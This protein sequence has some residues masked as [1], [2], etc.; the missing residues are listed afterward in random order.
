MTE[1][2]FGTDECKTTT[3]YETFARGLGRSRGKNCLGHRP[4]DPTT[5]T[6][7]PYSWQ[8][9]EEVARRRDAL[10]AG[11]VKLHD[12]NRTQY[13]VG[14]FSKNRPEWAITD[15]ACASQSLVSVALYDTLGAD[16]TEYIVNHCEM[17]MVVCSL[18]HVARLLNTKHNM[19][20]LRFIVS[21][22]ELDSG[23]LEGQS[24]S[25]MLKLWASEKNVQVFSFK[26]V[27]AL[28]T[29]F[30]RAHCIP[31]A[32]DI[33]T[34]NYTSGTTGNPKGAVLQHRCVPAA[35]LGSGAASGARPNDVTFSSLP[36]A[37]CYQRAIDNAAFY[38]GASI[39]YFHGD[40]LAL[41]EDM[42][43]LQPTIFPSV[44][45]ILSRFAAAIRLASINAPGLAG[46]I[47]RT[48]YA[49]KK[50]KIEAGGDNTHVLWDRI[51]C[52][53]IRA[54]FGGRLRL[55]SSGSAPISKDDYLFL[56]AALA[57]PVLNG[58][59]LTETNATACVAIPGDC[60]VG[61]CGPP[62]PLQEFK[63]R[64][65][66]SMNYSA[67]DPVPKGE[68]MVRGPHI[69]KEYL[70]EPTKT[71]EA[72]TSDGWFMT[73][74]IFQIDERGRFGMIDRVKNFFKLAQGEYVAP[75]KVEN[76]LLASGICAQ[77]FVHGNSEES[78]LVA[79]GGVNPDEFCPWASKI[80][81]RVVARDAASIQAACDEKSVKEAYLQVCE[82]NSAKS[83]LAGFEK[84]KRI[85]LTMD[86]FTAENDLLTPTMKVKRSQAAKFYKAQIDTMYS[87]KMP[88]R[89][90]KI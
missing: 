63:L 75:E 61:H 15:L 20:K 84:V 6:Y 10:G 52:K 71:A 43:L 31:S 49:A 35:A 33:W 44:P 38:S 32:E 34:I 69:F 7:G 30:P 60:S 88:D 76:V 18:D 21:M 13:C 56:N 1:V 48:A 50:A 4:Y 67:E 70:K 40:M 54:I 74:D 28:G 26:E 8:T 5:K 73:G 68:L 45:R 41:V 66:P 58:Y 11:I 29:A 24:T 27:E 82:A 64:S 12:N 57:C 47:S 51:W 42:Q 79:I 39:G 78:Y 81:G 85:Y 36:L 46:A 9:Y 2:K 72:L 83:R 25:A 17:E 16:S 22:D 87:E 23:E 80:L 59:G 77:I 62:M 86:P 89:L 65:V 3:A 90:A 53:K 55:I 14:I 37:H 19:P